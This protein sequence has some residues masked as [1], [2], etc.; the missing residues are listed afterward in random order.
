MSGTLKGSARFGDPAAKARRGLPGPGAYSL[1]T[2]VGRQPVSTKRSTPVIGFATADRN[3]SSKVTPCTV[4][5]CR[6]RYE[7][8]GT[9]CVQ[10]VRMQ[11]FISPDHEKSF[12]GIGSPG[13]GTSNPSKWIG[14]TELSTQAK[15]PAWGFGTARPASHMNSNPGPGEYYA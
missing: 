13:P 6:A 12:Y 15:A 8:V 11:I 7:E 1:P 9:D 14:R 4:S 5:F 2:A 10:H 3:A